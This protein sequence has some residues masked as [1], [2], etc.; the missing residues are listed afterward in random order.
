MTSLDTRQNQG[1]RDTRQLYQKILDNKM[2]K[3]YSVRIGTKLYSTSTSKV[4]LGK[5]KTKTY[6]VTLDQLDT[7]HELGLRYS[8]AS[9]RKDTR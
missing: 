8:I 7:R 9:T 5:P 1:T 3:R 2:N 4:I 6:S